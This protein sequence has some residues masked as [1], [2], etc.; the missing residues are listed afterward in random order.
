VYYT[1]MIGAGSLGQWYF[2]LYDQSTQRKQR[3]NGE[4]QLRETP[5]SYASN[6]I[7]LKHLGTVSLAS[8]LVTIFDSIRRVVRYLEWILTG[9]TTDDCCCLKSILNCT[10]GCM[11]KCIG[12]IVDKITKNSC[13]WTAVWGDGFWLASYSSWSLLYQNLLRVAAFEGVAT[14]VLVMGKIVV[15]LLTTGVCSLI[16]TRVKYFSEQ[17]D[18]VALPAV[19][20]FLVSYYVANVVLATYE[21]VIDTIFLCFLIDEQVNGGSGNMFASARLSALVN[22]YADQS[23]AQAAVMK[24]LRN[25]ARDD[26]G[27]G[28]PMI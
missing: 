13:V 12:C 28:Q 7:F 8:L 10:L 27:Q 3:G 6:I 18:S 21:S 11:L 24:G 16:L 22:K 19:I 25:K 1:Y 14:Y 17:L 20:I 15:S 2:A 9:L 4:H 5:V 26:Q 23:K